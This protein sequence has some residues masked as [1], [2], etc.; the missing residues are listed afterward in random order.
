MSR[1]ESEGTRDRLNI[2]ESA[3][4]LII[5]FT[6]TNHYFLSKLKTT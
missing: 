4:L 3:I 1:K 2:K 6:N 5:L